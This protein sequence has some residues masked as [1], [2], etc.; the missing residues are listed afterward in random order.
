MGG[1]RP[2]LPSPSSGSSRARRITVRQ[3][4]RWAVVLLPALWCTAARTQT[5]TFSARVEA[6]RVDVLVTEDG[7]PLRGLGRADF[8]LLDNGVRQQID[9]IS[10]E[11]IPLNLVL[12]LDVSESVQGERLEH[13]RAAS[14]TLLG[15]LKKGD[16]TALVAFS[17][18]V[19]LR[20]PLTGDQSRLDA[21]IAR[22][23]AGG[24]TALIDAA[25]AGMVL[26][27]SD[28]GRSLLILF[29]DG[30][31]TSSY[32]TRDA[33][34]DTAKRS[35]AVV[36]AVAVGGAHDSFLR[37]VARQ[38]GGRVLELASTKDLS[39]SFV[40][41]LEEFRE[42][43]LLSYSPRGVARDGWHELTVRLRG[44]RTAA[45]KARPGYLAGF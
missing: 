3:L 40:A 24:G 5:P 22:I 38:T 6:V 35:D 41:I 17:H 10:F 29:T 21:A 33:V 37:E 28:A 34:L 26:G 39:K 45:V 30:I 44:Q 1:G 4:V 14:R 16:H 36:Y 12:V 43:Y 23:E 18:V 2:V 31:D 15:G 7:Q 11:Q 25:Y 27:E 42:R 20:S 13:L 8:D 9:L 32:L 19:S